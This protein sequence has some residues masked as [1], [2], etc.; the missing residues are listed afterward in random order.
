MAAHRYW[1]LYFPNSC[2][3]GGGYY[4]IGEIEMCSA[5]AGADLTTP[6]AAVSQATASDYQLAGTEAAQA[7]DNNIT[8]GGSAPYHSWQGNLGTGGAK[9]WIAYDF[10]TA[11]DIVEIRVYPNALNISRTFTMIRFQSSDDN[12]TWKDEWECFTTWPAASWQTFAKPAFSG[13]AAKYW[14]IAVYDTIYA[15]GA[16]GEIAGAASTIEMH[17]SVGGAQ[18]ATG[19]SAL[20]DSY[21]GASVPAN[22]FDADP[23]TFWA[24]NVLGTG[25]IGYNFAAPVSVVE[26]KW[27]ARNDTEYYKQS[28]VN[29]SILRSNDGI[30]WLA[31]SPITGLTWAG[32]LSSNTIPITGFAAPAGPSRR[33]FAGVS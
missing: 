19:G 21:N 6:A 26:M 30:T 11:Q 28:V 13:N 9:S 7:F 10:L 4:G 27:I 29:G 16:I 3:A 18:M 14:G 17:S 8:A 15:Y 1:R 33:R 20:T 31:Q 25:I 22:A 32:A 23:N 5:Y 24:S 2:A 12:T